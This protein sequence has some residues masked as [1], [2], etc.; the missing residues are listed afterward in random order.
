MVI[1]RLRDQK[2]EIGMR[3]WRMRS[4]GLGRSW[5]GFISLECGG[6]VGMGKRV[7]VGNRPRV[8]NTVFQNGETG[9]AGWAET[10]NHNAFAFTSCCVYL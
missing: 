7:S 1:R 5:V 2:A 10:E 9:K 8:F 6:N 4:G 3:R